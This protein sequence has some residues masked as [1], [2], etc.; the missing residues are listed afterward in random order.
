M[1]TILFFNSTSIK[2][3]GKKEY[4]FERAR[5]PPGE[6]VHG[7]VSSKSVACPLLCFKSQSLAPYIFFASW[8]TRMTSSSPLKLSKNPFQ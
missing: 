4:Y 2:L 3:E 8:L 7:S 6:S 1:C 5:K